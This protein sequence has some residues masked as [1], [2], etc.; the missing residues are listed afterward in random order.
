[1]RCDQNLRKTEFD[2]KSLLNPLGFS[3]TEL[4][5]HSGDPTQPITLHEEFARRGIDSIAA[6]RGRGAVDGICFKLVL[7]T[8]VLVYL[9][10]IAT[11]EAGSRRRV[12]SISKVED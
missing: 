4:L 6:R 2:H 11:F 1:M 9:H 5:S 3:T 7:L 10:W 12:A 8:K